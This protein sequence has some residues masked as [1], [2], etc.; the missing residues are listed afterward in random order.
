MVD[1]TTRYDQP[2][3]AATFLV[4]F[5]KPLSHLRVVVVVLLLLDNYLKDALID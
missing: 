4:R 2:K 5:C 1:N 3:S